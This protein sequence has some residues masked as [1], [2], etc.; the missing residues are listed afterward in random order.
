MG[1]LVLSNSGKYQTLLL[2][3]VIFQTMIDCEERSKI[4]KLKVVKTM[5][6]RLLKLEIMKSDIG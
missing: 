5:I 2:V 6:E 3:K 1:G 4:T